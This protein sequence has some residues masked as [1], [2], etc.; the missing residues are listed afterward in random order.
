MPRLSATRAMEGTTPRDTSRSRAGTRSKPKKRAMQDRLSSRELF[1]RRLRRSLRPGLWVLGGVLVLVVGSE[2]FRA[3]PA[4]PAP[5]SGSMRHGFAAL[6]AAMGFRVTKIEVHGADTVSPDAIRA[7]LGIQPG[8]PLLG[9]SLLR[10]QSRVEA[11]GPIR[12]AVVE[13]AWPHTVIVTVKERAPYAIWQTSGSEGSAKLP[14]FVVIDKAGKVIADQNAVKA[15]RRDPGLLLITG[16]DAPQTASKLMDALKAAPAVRSHVVA[17]ERVDGLRWNL[18]LRD[19][20]LVKLPEEDQQ[21]AI[22]ELSR[23]QSSMSLLDRPVEV[24]DLRL[25]GRLAIRPYP[26][27]TDKDK[28]KAG[29]G[30]K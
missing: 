17:A 5:G 25:P 3:I 29:A 1:L 16:Q 20:T 9:F 4:A 2:I 8:D 28:S 14:K 21:Q 10:A 11:L 18:I 12:S 7:A 22:D 30:L 15:K 27:P 13:R 6:A 23:L 19:N 24:I 26:A